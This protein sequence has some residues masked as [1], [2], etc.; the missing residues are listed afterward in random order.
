MQAFKGLLRKD[1][2]L[3][4]K[5]MLIPVWITL[6]FLALNIL[7]LGIAYIENREDI[8][9]GLNQVD[10][11]FDAEE[12]GDVFP[13]VT[14]VINYVLVFLP[15]LL[16]LLMAIALGNT[17]LNAERNRNCLSFYCSLPIPN[18]QFSLSK[19]LVN[20]VGI[21]AIILGICLFDFIL[22]NGFIGIA[23]GHFSSMAF[24]GLFLGFSAFFVTGLLWG[25]FAFFC[26][27]LFSSSAFFK[28]FSAL[29][30]L[31][32]VVA[33]LNG[34]YGWQLPLPINEFVRP[35]GH[36]FQNFAI[37]EEFESSTGLLTSHFWQANLAR[38]FTANSLLYVLISAAFYGAGTWVFQKKEI[39]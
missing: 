33:V 1:W 17:A 25:G 20:I 34:V 39:S 16:G 9:F 19:F 2:Q 28:G 29:L 30:V 35:I 5:T 6:G 38:I 8:H 7:I 37:M 4:R 3:S 22:V 27:S 26:S 12:M 31:Q 32:A 23:V 18:W 36:V 14:F 10:W 15:G 13:G 11:D 24:H 21:W